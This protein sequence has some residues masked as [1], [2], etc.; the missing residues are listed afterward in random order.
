MT[1]T[2]REECS[3]VGKGAAEGY[4][5]SDSECVAYLGM[6]VTCRWGNSEGEAD[7]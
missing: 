6:G 7:K 2:G 3:E 1:E 5:K 4:C